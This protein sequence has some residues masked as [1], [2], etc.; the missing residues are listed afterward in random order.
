M[1]KKFSQKLY[2]QNDLKTKELVYKF[3]S[4]YFPCYKL[5]PI[6]DQEECY[7][8]HDLVIIDTRTNKQVLLEV[9][10]KAVWYKRG[11]WQGWDTVDIPYRKKDSKAKYFFMVNKWFDTLP[12]IKMSKI[13]ESSVITKSTIY[14]Q[15]EK[16]FRI[17]VSEF[18]LVCLPSELHGS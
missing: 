1:S 2:D 18:K 6:A 10:R 12:V 13:L 15:E 4:L 9:E 16:F 7:K 5:I 3:L 11:E 8:S 14:T 17:P